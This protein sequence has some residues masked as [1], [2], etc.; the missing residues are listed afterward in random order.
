MLATVVP[1]TKAPQVPSGSPAA[2]T[3]QCSAV[4]SSITEPGVASANSVF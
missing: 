4:A 3:I 2:S 1:V